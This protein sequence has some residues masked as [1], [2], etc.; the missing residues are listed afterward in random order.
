MPSQPPEIWREDI[1]RARAALP[2]ERVLVVSVVG[3]VQPD[4]TLERLAED[5][6]QCA[7]W[8]AESGADAVEANFSCPNVSTCD[9]QLYQQ[10]HDAQLV[11]ARIRQALGRVPLVIK[12]GHL[13]TEPAARDL[14]D[15]L[16]P[17]VD[18]IST[19]NSVAAT[20]ADASGKLLFDGQKRGI[21]GDAIRTASLR[22]VELLR[23]AI[24][25]GSLGYEL[26]G[27]G[28]ASTA[29]HVRQ[30][31]AAGATHV[32]LATAAMVDPLV[33]VRIRE[34]LAGVGRG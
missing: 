13:T 34:E 24:D 28:G 14:L 21:C 7:A 2:A 15:T 26:I 32:Q 30:Y 17:Y 1:R 11:A 6:A 5:Y 19:T 3:S 10:P 25:R 9:G 4:W 29:E 16:A 20:V 22:Q 33:G 23:G 31:L 27:V 12:I 8:A 18:A